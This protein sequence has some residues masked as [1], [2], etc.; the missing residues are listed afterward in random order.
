[1]AKSSSSIEQNIDQG[2]TE[3]SISVAYP[4]NEAIVNKKG[5]SKQKF[6]NKKKAKLKNWLKGMWRTK[7]ITESG[8]TDLEFQTILRE[9]IIYIIYLIIVMILTFGMTSTNMYWYTKVLTDLFVS[10]PILTGESEIN[11][12]ESSQI[13]HFWGFA[14]QV[15]INNL[16]WDF[17]YHNGD[18]VAN[19]T[20]ED[21]NILYENK[22]I[23]VPRLRQVKVRNDSC[24]VHEDFRRTFR[25]CYDFYS[26][27]AE[28]KSPF[29]PGNSKAWTY[30][31]QDQLG[32][33]SHWGELTTYGGGG[34]YVDLSIDKDETTEIVQ[35][36][37]ENLW[38]TRGTRAIFFD[39]TVY[40]ANINLFC[41]VKLLFEIPPTG[42]IIPS[43]SIKTV[44]LLRYVQ[45]FDYFVLGCEY[46]FIIFIL[47]Y[48]IEEIWEIYELRFKYLYSMWNYMDLTILILAY[49]LISFSIY[50]HVIIK[51]MIVQRL[52]DKTF[53]NF[54][55]IGFW[56]IQF[57]NAAAV[58]V[59]LV[60]VKLFKYVRFNKTMSQL[61]I[62]LSRCARDIAGFAIM[63]F[64][65]FFAFAQLGYL[66][67]GTQV[68][69]FRTFG[70]S[71]FT[72]LRTILG[73]FD[74]A[75]IEEANRVLGPIF[76]ISYIFFVFFVLLNMF[77]AI[78]NDTYSD[79]KSEI[80]VQSSIAM[81]DYIKRC[82]Q[83]LFN[84][85]GCKSKAVKKEEPS[86]DGKLTYKEIRDALKKCNF[87]DLEI[88]MFFAKYDIDE[89]KPVG[90]EDTRR[91]L[92][93][94]EGRRISEIPTNGLGA[95]GVSQEDYLSLLNRVNHM[96]DS[97]ARAVEK[98]ELVLNKLEEVEKSYRQR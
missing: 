28:D 21:R 81:N 43:Y 1:M 57:N 65:I 60:W 87:T 76:F 23:G 30:S 24:L 53:A 11:F 32:G 27:A 72:L 96:E 52:N 63:F 45:P 16:Y 47:F 84:K 7:Q 37:K 61:S 38:V 58:M 17:W 75:A 4:S 20:N 92:T 83:N 82:F 22:L 64:I 91:M 33:F 31:T 13:T 93:D 41:I 3:S 49:V 39:F 95:G 50:R 34:Y 56:Q 71:I 29:G 54:E 69:D 79:V 15:M 40:N 2:E 68:E 62:T 26:H 10:S 42:G 74:Y 89:D 44:K 80:S 59:F 12:K 14:E 97:I 55:F 86:G 35:Y 25:T 67:F 18:P 70:T 98:V 46:I 90:E 88:E 6:E 77:L 94:L 48:T 85:L 78:I 8:D 5:G 73:D 51:P 66:L 9:L 36:L 19:V